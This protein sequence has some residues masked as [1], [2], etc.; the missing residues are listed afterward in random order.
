MPRIDDES[1]PSANR[2]YLI[3]GTALDAP[4]LAA[5]LHIVS[6]PIGNLSDVTIRALATLAAADLILAEDTRLSR[7][8]LSHYGIS[9]PLAAYHDHNAAEMRPAV[10]G[11][12]GNRQ[13]V[14][15]ISDAGTPLISDPGYKLVREAAAAGHRIVPVPGASALLAA[16]VTAGLP[17]DR[18]HFEGFL[19]PKAVARRRRIEEL[20]AY[21][22][23][24]V[25]YES[26]RRVAGTL[27]D[28]AASLG[29]GRLAALARELT[30]FFEEV[31]R[32][33][34]GELAAAL[35][36]EPDPKGEIVLV[37][38]PPAEQPPPAAEDVDALLARVLTQSSVKDAASEVA[39]A[40]GLPRRDV[41][42]RALDLNK[43]LPK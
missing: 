17:T 3:G 25:I 33:T 24:L 4:S 16:L 29:E 38:A 2:R 10:L 39:R 20:K 42:A 36:S 6:T 23:T 5:G 19:P 18:F 32:G 22:A 8:L 26:P 41:Y 31:R 11:R 14:A 1:E 40:T 21:D 12:L 27:H 37:V 15:L 43:T 30:K 34:L 13:A 35:A 9:T 28:L 7:R